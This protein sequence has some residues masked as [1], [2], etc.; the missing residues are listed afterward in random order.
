MVIVS[1]GYVRATDRDG[2]LAG[3][4]GPE[5]QGGGEGDRKRVLMILRKLEDHGR[6]RAPQCRAFKLQNKM[7]V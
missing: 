5:A 3:G 6:V 7:N 2:N 1:G 4:A